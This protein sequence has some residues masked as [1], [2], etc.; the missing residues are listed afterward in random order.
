MKNP[1]H[2]LAAAITDP[3]RYEDGTLNLEGCPDGGDVNDIRSLINQIVTWLTIGI[4]VASV[5]FIIISGL[6]MAS[7]SGDPD[8]VKRARRTLLYSVIGLAVAILAG[9]IVNIVFNVSDSLVN[10]TPAATE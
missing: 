8:K 9:I 6:Q 2:L 10:Q 1:F 3:C 7:S 5:V 4:G